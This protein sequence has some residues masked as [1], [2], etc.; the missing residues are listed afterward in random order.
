MALPHEAKQKKGDK[1][2]QPWQTFTMLSTNLSIFNTF[3]FAQSAKPLN[4]ILCHI[5][6]YYLQLEHLLIWSTR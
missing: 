5:M 2:E 6:P 3:K 1:I 4:K